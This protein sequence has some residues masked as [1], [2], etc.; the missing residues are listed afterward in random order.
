MA[1]IVG[2]RWIDSEALAAV[3]VAL[4]PEDGPEGIDQLGVSA[5]PGYGPDAAGDRTTD[6]VVGSLAAEDLTPG[7]SHI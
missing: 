7:A 1:R 5:E 6:E 4:G 2:K 3:P